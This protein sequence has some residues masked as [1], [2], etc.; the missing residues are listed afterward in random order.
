VPR[1]PWAELVTLSAADIARW[2]PGEIRE[3]AAAAQARAR[4]ALDAADG[5]GRLPC[6][7]SW[8][9]R[10]ATAA[11]EAI[12]R[13]RRDLDAA[14]GEALL[15]GQAVRRAAERI[16]ALRS[17]LLRLEGEAAA[18]GLGVDLA[19]NR[20]FGERQG[21]EVAAGML[22]T[23]LNSIVAE[24]NSVD[25]ELAS[26]LSVGGAPVATLPSPG[27]A[28]AP[29]DGSLPGDPTQF[30]DHWVRLSAAQRDELF[31]R[32]PA[33]GNHPGMPAGSA[34]DPGSDHYN[35]RHL[36]AA[37]A[38]ARASGS[39]HL[40]DFE[41][42]HAQLAGHPDRKL[43]LFDPGSGQRVHAAIAVGDPDTA[44]HVSVT[45]PGLNT[46]VAATM[47]GMVSEATSLRR[48]ALR[49][50]SRE[51]LRQLSRAGGRA[52]QE[53]AAIAWIG[54]DTPQVRL[55][56][57]PADLPAVAR[58]LYQVSHDDAA[59]A[60]AADLARFYDGIVAA[61]GGA[62]LNLTAIGHSYGS[63]TTGLAL[64]Q[65]GRHGV[66]AA[67]FYGSPGVEAAT[68]AQL[69]LA[70][71]R[72]FTMATPDDPIR[73]VYD[74]PPIARVMAQVIPGT[75]DDALLG[76]ADLSRAGHFGPD[77]ATN[78]N[79]VHLETGPVRAPDGWQLEGAAGHSQYPEP[80]RAGLPRTTGYNIAA[81]V[82]GLPHNVIERA[83]SGGG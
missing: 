33:I 65:P 83:R 62:P 5:L 71:G 58:G 57:D 47:A 80:G 66:D 11:A 1:R 17:E 15:V 21:S 22:Q 81:V 16:E 24:S 61:R 25:V 74:G 48:E 12:A 32:D 40:A 82:A 53:V 75:V 59:K 56:D 28:D 54:Y 60:G 29:L 38:A 70:S 14:A 72:V 23:R 77:P 45:T 7:T 27:L 78:P 9:G 6:L 18:C 43:M 50:L 26:A 20:I 39:Q 73:W 37:L 42:L 35:R 51:A 3:V 79:F 41:E 55:P 4:A 34:T 13:T 76:A 46:T 44:E 68:P 31:R 36:A 2:D 64:Q 30:R 19:G 8:G 49:Q 69:G 67:I 63:L 52:E 10:A